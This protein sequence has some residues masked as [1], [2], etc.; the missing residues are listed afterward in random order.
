MFNFRLFRHSI[1]RISALLVLIVPLMA[2]P[3]VSMAGDTQSRPRIGLVLG[4]GGA[5]GMAHVGVLKILEEMRIPVDCVAG[6]S[7]GSIIGGLYASG[8]SPDTMEKTLARIDWLEVFRDGPPRIDLPF[9]T[10]QDQRVL[11]N[12]EVGL[13]RDGVQ[14]PKGL[15]EGQNLLLLLEELA[16]PAARVNN[17]DQLRLPYRAVA[18]DLATGDPVVLGSGDLA[19][20]MRASMSIPSAL[21]PVKL[22]GKLLVDGGVANNLP[23][24]VIRTLC[25]PDV[26]IAVEVGAPLAQASQI[27]SVLSVTNQITTILTVRNVVAQIK[28]LNK[29]DILI[30][31]DLQDVTSID[32]HRFSEAV[33]FGYTAAQQQHSALSR[34]SVTPAVYQAYIAGLPTVPDAGQ[35]P[36][37]D[38]VRIDNQT[39][40]SDQVIEQQLDIQPG[41]RLD[42]HILNRNLNTLYGM[43]DFQRVNYTL[44]REQGK[45]GLIVETVPRDIGTNSLRFGLFLGANL[46]GDSEFDVS[47]AYTLSELNSL[48]GQWRNFLQLGGNTVFTSD[49]YQPL[50]ADQHYFID[51]YLRYEQYNLDLFEGTNQK[52]ASFRVHRTEVGVEIGRNLARSGRWVAGLHYGTGSNDSR[53]GQSS[54]SEDRFHDAGY[55]LRWEMDTLDNIS[56]PN[57]GYASNLTFRDSLEA[58]GADHDLRTLSFSFARAYTWNKSSII[59]RLRLAGRISGQTGVEN[60]FTLGGFLNLSGYQPGQISGEYAALG[61]V[62]YLYRLDSASSAFALPV[63]VGGS[64]EAGGAWEESSEIGLDSLIP[65]G[66]LFLG[67]DTPLGP[68]YLALGLAKGGYMS[69]SILLGKL[70]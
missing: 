25:H 34:L 8:M 29:N 59:P 49:F 26:I 6:T 33:R 45:T 51:P 50:T 41:D 5:R 66:S 19:L 9:R 10:K 52:S 18:T 53:I 38:F 47:A 39:R 1:G 70:F 28:T 7:M 57:S 36:I 44:A 69:T 17:F 15:L 68:F 63:Y 16:L 20:A 54:V 32:F 31:P 24:D 27:N 43:G 11:L 56:F 21:V 3:S 35:P 55:S 42:P 2:P 13:S 46:K 65:A 60:R 48:G 23:I 30:Q 4:G 37:I 40:L 61:E 14:L 64:L 12:A 22:D 58:L 62:I 67:A